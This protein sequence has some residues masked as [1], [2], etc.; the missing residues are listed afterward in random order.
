M[1]KPLAIHPIVMAFFPALFLYAHNIDI[2][3]FYEVFNPALISLTGAVLVWLATTYVFKDY[4]R[5]G[6]LT[7]VAL[8]L[9]FSYGHIFYS[10]FFRLK[11]AGLEVGR[12]RY[13]FLFYIIGSA[14]IILMIV[15]LFRAKERLYGCT[16]Y[17]NMV[18][19]VL[20]G[21]SII[22]IVMY[23]I[24]A[25]KASSAITFHS[26][27]GTKRGDCPARCKNNMPDI[28]YI[29]LDMYASS[30]VL[31]DV[32]G[33]DNSSFTDFLEER[34]FYVAYNSRANYPVTY[35]SLASS[36]NMGYVNRLTHNL[37]E[38]SRDRSILYKMIGNFEKKKRVG[39][40]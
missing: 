29:V 5:A 13:F 35:L 31:K 36:L 27:M 24:S 17:L 19:F 6:V 26:R 10:F 33:Y 1:K 40:R 21:M 14:L 20:V 7:T 22:N 3:S 9:F 32:F 23:H 2:T 28:Y 18:S 38:E 12:E 34:G 4:L 25:P 16:R 11:I 15:R 37:G 39:N 30:D 8:I